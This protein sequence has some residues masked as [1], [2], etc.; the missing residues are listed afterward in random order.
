MVGQVSYKIENDIQFKA[1]LD[2]AIKSVGDL[3]FV[4]GEISR[5]IFKTTKQNF[6]LKGDGKISFIKQSLCKTQS[7]DTWKFANSCIKWRVKGFSNRSRK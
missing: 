7:C 4:M 2:S 6:I 1:N 3:R 5:D